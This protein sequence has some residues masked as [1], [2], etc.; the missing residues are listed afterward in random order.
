MKFEIVGPIPALI[1]RLN[2]ASRVIED[3]A[4]EIAMLSNVNYALKREISILQAKSKPKL[5]EVKLYRFPNLTPG[6]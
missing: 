5:N 3:Q 2:I 4:A 6:V 1:S